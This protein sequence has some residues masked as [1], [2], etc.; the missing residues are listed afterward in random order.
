MR[1]QLLLFVIAIL[2]FAVFW[3]LC[4]INSR[5]KKNFSTSTP[6]RSLEG[7]KASLQGESHDNVAAKALD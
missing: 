6:L 2:L 3:E 5:L 7:G 1:T 4:K